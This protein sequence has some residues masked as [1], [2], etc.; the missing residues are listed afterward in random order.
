MK[1]D[2]LLLPIFVMVVVWLTLGWRGAAPAPALTEW[3]QIL[4][5]LR[6]ECDP[7]NPE[8]D[9]TWTQNTMP[10]ERKREAIL[11]RCRRLGARLLPE[12]RSALAAEKSDE[13]RGMLTVIAAAL[14]DADSRLPAAKEMTWSYYP[15]LKISAALT[16]RRLKDRELIPWFRMALKDDHF[17][18]NGGCGLLREK[19]FPVRS[20]AETALRDFGIEPM[21]EETLFRRLTEL[22]KSGLSKQIQ[23][24]HQLRLLY[25][26]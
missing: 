23:Q 6:H 10:T 25:G 20:L 1:H 24:E 16:L 22:K 5:E 4:A 8:A 15:A 7:A 17:V 19:F 2:H 14:G 12:V 3:P 9:Y 18:V 26:R 13:V 11:Q 21:D